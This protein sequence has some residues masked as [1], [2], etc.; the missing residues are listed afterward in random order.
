MNEID[1]LKQLA[2]RGQDAAPA[3][4]VVDGV[5]EG[6]ARGRISPN[7]FYGAL[8]GVTAAAA[9]AVCILAVQALM[10]WQDPFNELLRTVM[11]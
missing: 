10:A 5:L 6:I 9:T 3:V 11:Q 4:N 1:F 7:W 8:A 2:S